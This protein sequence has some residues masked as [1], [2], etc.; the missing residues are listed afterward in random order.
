MSNKILLALSKSV[1]FFQRHKVPYAL[2]GAM[3]LNMYGR[4]RTTLDIDFLVLLDAKDLDDI[5]DKATTD[6]IQIDE[7]WTK[8]NPLLSRNHV[9]F[10]INE[11]AI[12]LMLPRD[13]HDKQTLKRRKKK[14]VNSKMIWIVAPEDLILQKLKVGRPRDFEDAL[15]VLERLS[16]KLDI[17][18]LE[19]LAKRIGISKELY[20]I[21]DL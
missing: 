14:K 3:A 10:I 12:D 5:K 8:H 18:Y 19:D 11:I 16:G 2:T 4:P 17:Q 21:M 6:K 15:T 7:E 13:D 20:Y 9:R 1:L